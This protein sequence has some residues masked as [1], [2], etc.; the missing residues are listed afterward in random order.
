[1][2]DPLQAAEKPKQK[3]LV[4]DDDPDVLR[5]VKFVL[6]A[7]GYQVI[8]A[9]NGAEALSKA[10]SEHPQLVILDVMMPEISG[11]EV[12]W[13]LRDIPETAHLPI[14]IVSAKGEVP[15]RVTGLH[16]GADD[17]LV[18]P[19]SADELLARVVALLSRTQRGQALARAQERGKIWGFVGAKGGAGVSTLVLNLATLLAQQK[20]PAIAVE[21]QPNQGTFATQL[22]WRGGE[23]LR[24]LLRRDLEHLDA[25][26]IGARLYPTFTGLR[27]LYGPQQVDEF[28][29][30]DADHVAPVIEKLGQMADTL[31]LDLP[32]GASGA[33][34]AAARA[35]DL[36]IVVMEAEPCAL[37]CAKAQLDLLKSWDIL[38]ALV[39]IVLVSRSGA[40]GSLGLRDLNQQLGS[41]IVG[42]VPFAGELAS[43]AI[44]QGLPMV[45]IKPEHGITASFK[46]ILRRLSADT[47]IGI[48]TSS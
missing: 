20:K 21:L 26:T 42:I 6:H 41:E 28:G 25:R 33:N 2:F 5:L 17:Y 23:N 45:V 15:D 22:K 18:K 47:L 24:H 36:V 8:T 31:L 29:D 37:Q 7:A 27:V 35:C 38:G 16:A 32:Y 1:M 44:A 4:V 34:R 48:R 10:Q 39:G 12:C 3:I 11:L 13:R 46:E 9:T 19:V 30:L 43:L 14:I 40:P